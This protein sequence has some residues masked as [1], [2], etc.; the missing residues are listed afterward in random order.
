MDL[1]RLNALYAY[2]ADHPPI[3]LLVA[4]YFGIKPKDKSS[5][6]DT[7]TDIENAAEFIPVNKIS[8]SEFDAVLNGFGL[9]TE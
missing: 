8:S 1:P 4:A 2:W 7:F 9:P 3:H 6:N 5:K